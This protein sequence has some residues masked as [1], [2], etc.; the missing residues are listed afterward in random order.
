MKF[1]SLPRFQLTELEDLPWFP[2]VVRAGMMDCLR[3]FFTLLNVY[4]STV[5]VVC[6]LLKQANKTTVLDLCS[7]GGGASAQV[8]AQL[9]SNCIPDAELLLSD[10][11]PNLAAF[12][13]L[14]QQAGGA[15]GFIP[16]PVNA[17]QVPEG[18]PNVRTLYTAFH[19][20][21]PA[22]A[23][24][25]LV[26]CARLK[27]YIGIFEGT[28]RSWVNLL[29]VLPL[30]LLVWLATPFIRPFSWK[31]LLF[32]YLIPLIPLGV[33]W[34]GLVSMLRLYSIE[35]LEQMT[36]AAAVPGYKWEVRQIKHWLGVQ[37]VQIVGMP[38]GK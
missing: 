13:Y 35:E 27:V 1:L 23:S 32:T 26:S 7:G 31:R 19:H 5:P 30:P 21:T 24:E 12:Q 4:K 38:V 37:T 11:Y 14:Q 16:E 3:F 15:L 33:F 17:L 2:G 20:F 9:R 34:D 22:N 25:M 8:L 28:S 10:L 6:D 29:L 18:L 36:A